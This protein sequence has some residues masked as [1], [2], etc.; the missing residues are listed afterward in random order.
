[1]ILIMRMM[2]MLEEEMEKMNSL[3]VVMLIISLKRILKKVVD[4]C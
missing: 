2:K 4:S 1:M 3:Q